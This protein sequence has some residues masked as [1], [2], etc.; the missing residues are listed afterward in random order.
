[1]RIA[2]VHGP[3]LNLLGRREP[4]HYGHATLAEIDARLVALGA[5]LGV[6][7]ESFQSNSEGALVDH[8]QGAAD[9]AAGFV[10][11]AGG[12]THTSVALRDALSAVA[13]PYV[14]VHLSNVW[15]REPFR[16]RS[17]LAE[18]ALGVIG[19]FGAESYLLGLRAV[20]THLQTAGDA[21]RTTT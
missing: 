9:A 6:E 21:P 20:V 4:E 8:V 5:S 10:I 7:V 18:G 1:M 13:R 11:N 17:L 15:A 19:G 16:H 12:Y 2:V 14:E 3:N